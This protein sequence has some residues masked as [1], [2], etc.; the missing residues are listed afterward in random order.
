MRERV[1]CRNCGRYMTS[2]ATAFGPM[3]E[4]GIVVLVKMESPAVDDFVCAECG[5]TGLKNFFIEGAS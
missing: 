4:E 2:A 3:D 5:A 1:K